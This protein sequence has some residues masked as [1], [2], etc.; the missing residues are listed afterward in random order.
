MKFKFFIFFLFLFL[1]FDVFSAQIEDESLEDCI[2]VFKALQKEG[3]ESSFIQM[4]PAFKVKF[5]NVIH[6]QNLLLEMW[7]FTA[8]DLGEHTLARDISAANNGLTESINMFI[9]TRYNSNINKVK[10]NARVLTTA[11]SKIYNL[12]RRANL[13]NDKVL[14]LNQ[15]LDNYRLVVIAA[16]SYWNDDFMKISNKMQIIE[17]IRR[18][19]GELKISALKDINKQRK[20]LSE[21]YENIWN[22]WYKTSIDML[23]LGKDSKDVE[24]A[25]KEMQNLQKAISDL[26]AKEK[27]QMEEIERILRG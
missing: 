11:L 6:A 4:Y 19:V 20:E 8:K 10:D 12:A 7:I 24:S 17:R 15:K 5:Q 13:S 1:N 22:K 18:R 25:T 26:D 14:I 3:I 16:I 27:E 23:N 21:K 9:A 2:D